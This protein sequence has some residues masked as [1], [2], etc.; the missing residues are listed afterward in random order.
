MRYTNPR[1]LYFTLLPLGV[2]QGYV[3]GPLLYTVYVA[4][5]GKLIRNLAVIS[6]LMIP[7][8]IPSVKFL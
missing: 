2:P 1:L 3:L 6:I 8:C 4:V 7:T 5:M